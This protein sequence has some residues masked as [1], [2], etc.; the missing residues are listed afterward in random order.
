MKCIMMINYTNY[1]KNKE[2]NA[3]IAVNKKQI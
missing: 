1:N 2:K 3:G